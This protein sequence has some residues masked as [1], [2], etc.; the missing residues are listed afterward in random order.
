MDMDQAVD[1]H[2]GSI[3]DPDAPST[4]SAAPVLVPRRLIPSA[5]RTVTD[6]A[7]LRLQPAN[8][9]RAIPPAYRMATMS[10]FHHVDEAEI[11][12]LLGVP[13]YIVNHPDLIEAARARHC[14]L[15]EGSEISSIPELRSYFEE[16][17]RVRVY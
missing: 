4:S 2:E 3:T 12:A 14:L 11:R 6:I 17:D 8:S 9:A 7:E 10:F 16:L 13:M 15:Q 1:P 5:T